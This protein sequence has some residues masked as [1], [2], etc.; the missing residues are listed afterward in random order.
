MKF[1]RVNPRKQLFRHDPENGVH[2][3]CHRTAIAAILD[4]PT[5]EVPHFYDVG[6]TDGNLRITDFLAKHN[7]SQ[8]V[9]CFN[10]DDYVMVAQSIDIHNPGRPALL[11]GRSRTGVNHTVVVQFGSIICDPSLD[12]SGII[13]PCDDGYIW[14]EYLV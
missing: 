14:V 9:M 2:G 11:S 4:M 6:V 7:K 3:D 8:I 13:G 12:D 1:A 5:H 10:C